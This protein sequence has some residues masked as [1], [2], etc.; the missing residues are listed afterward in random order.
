[1]NLLREI[2]HYYRFFR[3]TPKEDR[4]IIFYAESEGYYS[5][6][7][8]LIKELTGTCQKTVC[9]IT[10]D[11]HDSVLQKP[12]PRI[13][14]F[15]IH[16]LISFLMFFVK[17]K[18]F[19]MTLTDLNQ[20]HLRRSIH[21]VH[22]VYV[23]HAMVSTHMMYRDGAFN[24]Y[25]SILCVGP[26]HVKEILAYE[27]LHALPAK[28][29]VQAG[30]YRL[31]RIFMKYQ[32]YSAGQSAVREK[33]TVLIAPSWGEKNV[34]ESCGDRLIPLLLKKGYTV[35]VRPHP[36]TFRHTPQLV[37]KIETTFGAYP[38]FVLEKLVAT[39]DSLLKADVLICDLSGIALEF[40]FGT[41]RPVI[42]LDVPYKIK[43]DKYQELG[44]EP[45]ELSIRKEIGVIVSPEEVARVPQVIEK[46]MAENLEY[47]D[48]IAK[49]R[50]QNVYNF[51]HSSKKGAQH[52][53]D[54]MNG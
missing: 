49:L 18:V 19:I 11:P 20:F 48:C 2:A 41:E 40:A 30:Y 37:K 23:F 26:H 45:L 38:A 36:E 33:V 51:M 54:C 1:M 24:Y 5:Y 42:F 32:K 6:F 47:K 21:P 7:E 17:C 35:I 34:L 16:A 50:E 14:T 9:Y 44:I 4:N 52:I 12:E 3:R 43:N 46:L 27:A 15:Y 39:D 8:G 10:S 22:Y 25:D 31:E 29:L 13:K 28:D 53:I